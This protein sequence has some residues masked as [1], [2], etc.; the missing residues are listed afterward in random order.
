M[1]FWARYFIDTTL[2]VVIHI[3]RTQKM[4][5]GTHSVRRYRRDCEVIKLYRSMHA[6]RNGDQFF[7]PSSR[8]LRFRCEMR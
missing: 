8:N 3:P 4:G 5:G 7:Y 2:L 1:V 6:A